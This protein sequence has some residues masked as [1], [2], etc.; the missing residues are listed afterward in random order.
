MNMLKKLPEAIGSKCVIR[1]NPNPPVMEHTVP[2]KILSGEPV[3]KW[4]DIF[5]DP[6]NQFCVGIWESDIGKWEVDFIEDEFI[7]IISGRI[8]LTD[9]DGHAETFGPG[10]TVVVP[11]GF[12]GTWETVEPVRKWYVAFENLRD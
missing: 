5:V 8:T 1:C 6:T 12:K 9:Q 4:H 10:E 2:A 11:R 3:K 7:A